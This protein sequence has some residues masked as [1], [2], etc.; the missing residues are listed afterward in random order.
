[1]RGYS[2]DPRGRRTAHALFGG[3]NGPA[4]FAFS[5]SASGLVVVLLSVLVLSAP[6]GE[7]AS[8]VAVYSAPFHHSST[9]QSSYGV[10][11]NCGKIGTIS[12]LAWHPARGKVGYVGTT[13]TP[14]CPA[15]AGGNHSAGVNE[16][17]DLRVP[18][19]L[20]SSS[21][22]VQAW[23]NL[24]WSVTMSA[25]VGKC[26]PNGTMDWSCVEHSYVLIDGWAVLEDRANHTTSSAWAFLNL[27]NDSG[28]ARYCDNNG[29]CYSYSLGPNGTSFG[30]ASADFS[31]NLSG[32]NASHHYRLHFYY[33][34]SVVSSVYAFRATDSG[35]SAA[36]TLDWGFSGRGARLSSIAVT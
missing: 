9:A 15:A 34:L 13:S 28:W 25:T 6:L 3:G 10:V 1:M 12:P 11:I 2:D 32:L 33:E 22:Q 29:H 35:G 31:W 27:E 21:H 18:I 4:Y 17:M 7:S 23:W 30:T 16:L 24:S 14:T 5:R 36:C 20:S 8:P 26:H 19:N